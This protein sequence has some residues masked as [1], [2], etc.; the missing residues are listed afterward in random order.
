VNICSAE[1]SEGLLD[2]I[3]VEWI[4]RDRRGGM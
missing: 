2:L 1:C 4:I 3:V